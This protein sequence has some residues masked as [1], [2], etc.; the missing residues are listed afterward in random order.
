MAAQFTSTNGPDERG[1]ARWIACASNPL[2]VPVSP[3]IKMGGSRSLPARG[4]SN[5]RTCCRTASMRGCS[6]I[7]SARKDPSG[8]TTVVQG[9]AGGGKFWPLQ[10]C[11]QRVEGP[12]G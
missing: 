7:S 4:R 11:H 8:C 6:P 12:H 10:P 5:R 3:W 1:P 9:C 2:P